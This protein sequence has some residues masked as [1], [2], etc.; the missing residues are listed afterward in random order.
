MI[1]GKGALSICIMRNSIRWIGKMNM[2][3]TRLGIIGIGITRIA[4]LRSVQQESV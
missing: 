4:I 3:T 2:G 1:I